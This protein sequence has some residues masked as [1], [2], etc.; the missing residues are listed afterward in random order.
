VEGRD[1]GG[2]GLVGEVECATAVRVGLEGFDTI[3]DY[4]VGVEMLSAR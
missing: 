1:D 2:V 4:W 3:V